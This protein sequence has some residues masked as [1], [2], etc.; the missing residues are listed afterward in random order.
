[1]VA[2]TVNCGKC[3]SAEKEK[4]KALLARLNCH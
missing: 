2:K 4:K 3:D 1:M